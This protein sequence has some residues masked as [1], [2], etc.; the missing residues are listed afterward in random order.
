METRLHRLLI[1]ASDIAA[2]VECGGRTVVDGEIV[3]V[4]RRGKPQFRNLLFRRGEPCFFA[5]DLLILNGKDQRRD[6]LTDRKQE[7]RRLLSR[8]QPTST[9]KYVDH[10][11][12]NGT[13]LFRRVC[14]LDLEGI[15]AK[16]KSAPYVTSREESTWVK[17]LNPN[18]S[19]RERREELFERDRKKEPVAGWHSCTVACEETGSQFITIAYNP[20]R[21][22]Q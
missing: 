12:A 20:R 11:D 21:S 1:C 8:S 16:Q 17:I 14:K 2:H 4:D 10:I 13:A 5:F 18:Y 3:Y 15:V 9:L 7:L 19:Q 6:R 22:G